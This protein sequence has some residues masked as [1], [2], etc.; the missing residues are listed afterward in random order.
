MK[1]AIIAI[2]LTACA[3]TDGHFGMTFPYCD[4][5]CEAKK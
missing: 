5:A 4:A 1:I 2:L 3:N